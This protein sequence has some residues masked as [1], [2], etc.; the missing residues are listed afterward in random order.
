M[1]YSLQSVAIRYIVR[2]NYIFTSK[3]AI[4]SD[5]YVNFIYNKLPTFKYGEYEIGIAP[6][7]D[8]LEFKF[9]CNLNNIYLGFNP[10]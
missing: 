8:T 5:F 6:G 1:S 7:T 10:T 9:K 4:N 3:W 2:V